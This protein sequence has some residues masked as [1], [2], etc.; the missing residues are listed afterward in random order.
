MGLRALAR[1]L[2][3]WTSDP[4]ADLRGAGLGTLA[5]T[6][7]LPRRPD[8]DRRPGVAVAPPDDQSPYGRSVT[9][10]APRRPK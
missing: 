3:P 10:V 5:P 7:D 4:A 1:R 2:W 9:L 6:A 8:R